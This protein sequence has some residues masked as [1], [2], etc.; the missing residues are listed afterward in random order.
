MA[1]SEEFIGLPKYFRN[2]IVNGGVVVKYDVRT[3]CILVNFFACLAK[4]PHGDPRSVNFHRRLSVTALINFVQS[5]D[6]KNV[7]IYFLV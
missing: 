5:A 1:I 4:Q 2:V 7:L 6:L 3:S